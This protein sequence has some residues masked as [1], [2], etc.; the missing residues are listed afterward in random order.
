MKRSHILIGIGVAVAVLLAMLSVGP[1]LRAPSLARWVNSQVA[2]RLRPGSLRQ[3]DPKGDIW[4]LDMAS[5]PRRASADPN[6]PKAGPPIIVR[7]DVSRVANQVSIGLVLEGQAGERYRAV[8][9]NGR[10]VMAPKLRIVNE[11]GQGIVDDRFK[12]G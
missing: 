7:T 9:K 3:T 8:R 11:A 12:Y 1:I 2:G 5:G 10:T 6:R 4:Q